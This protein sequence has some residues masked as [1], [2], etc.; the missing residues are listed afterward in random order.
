MTTWEYTQLTMRLNPSADFTWAL[1][2]TDGAATAVESLGFEL[3]DVD[4]TVGEKERAR[5]FVAVRAGYAAAIV[6]AL[7]SFGRSGWELGALAEQWFAADGSSPAYWA[8]TATFKRP[9]DPSSD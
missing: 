4:A 2:R 5:G 3:I 7:N 1:A 8:V 9:T 6:T